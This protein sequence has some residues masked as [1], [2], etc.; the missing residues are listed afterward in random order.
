MKLVLGYLVATRIIVQ[1]ELHRDLAWDWRNYRVVVI[2]S[3]MFSSFHKFLKF[4][5]AYGFPTLL[6]CS[7]ILT[8]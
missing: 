5:L 8:F 7:P 6:S 3:A 4:L 1:K 2:I